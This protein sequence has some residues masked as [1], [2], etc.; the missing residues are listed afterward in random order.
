MA[1]YTA[2]LKIDIK[3]LELIGNQE[4]K[5]DN[6]ND[7]QK[8]QSQ[9]GLK[10][11]EVSRNFIKQKVSNIVSDKTNNLEST[12]DISDVD[13]ETCEIIKEQTNVKK[14]NRKRKKN[15]ATTNPEECHCLT[16]GEIFEIKL[17]LW[18]H[19]WEESHE[20]KKG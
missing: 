15:N 5:N 8:P 10:I 7:N 1:E 12:E 14:R 11:S 18:N 17:D 13:S 4:E 9:D 20:L 16:C 2:V 6:N 19:C 3:S